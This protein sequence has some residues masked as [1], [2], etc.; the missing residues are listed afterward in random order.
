M[1]K[2]RLSYS[3]RKC[4]NILLFGIAMSVVLVLTKSDKTGFIIMWGSVL[5][6]FILS[7]LYVFLRSLK[8]S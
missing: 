1:M 7:T 5:S 8:D 2:K 6:A 3:V 4:R